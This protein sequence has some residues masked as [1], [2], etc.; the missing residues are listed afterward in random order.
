MESGGKKTVAV[1]IPYALYRKLKDR[2]IVM[3]EV[4][5][6]ALKNAVKEPDEK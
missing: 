3:S 1:Q 4:M 6:E 5:R 2:K